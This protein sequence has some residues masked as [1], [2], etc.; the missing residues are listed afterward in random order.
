MRWRPS[1]Q[2]E[3]G[4]GWG[5]R[6]ACPLDVGGRVFVSEHRRDR[7]PQARQ[8]CGCPR[9]REHGIN[10]CLVSCLRHPGAAGTRDRRTD[11]GDL[12]EV[13]GPQAIAVAE[14]FEAKV[15]WFGHQA[16]SGKA[17]E[18]GEREHR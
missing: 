11:V 15:A 12:T 8:P 1:G 16:N 18:Q 17:I 2:P 6:I 10:Q 13:T 7:S 14:P 3:A 9:H 4:T 5:R